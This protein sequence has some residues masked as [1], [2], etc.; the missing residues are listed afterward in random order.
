LWIYRKDKTDDK[1]EIIK[2]DKF[3]DGGL[4][5]EFEEDKRRFTN[6]TVQLQKAIA[7]YF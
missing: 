7:L 1:A 3:P 5:F 4:E 6:H 2:P